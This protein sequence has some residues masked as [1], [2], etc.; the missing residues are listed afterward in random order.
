MAAGRYNGFAQALHWL[1][2]VLLAAQF[3]VAWTMPDVGRDTKPIGL[4]AWH[5]SI[6]TL[7]L[8]V[9][10]VRLG[11]RA[12]SAIPPPPEDLPASLR[13]LSRAT[14][15]LM[16]AV[17]IVLPALGWINANARG[18]TVRLAGAI[19]L[20]SLAPDGSSWGHDMGDVHM[21]VAWVLLGLVGLHVLGAVYHQ[22]VL[23]DHL[24]SRMLPGGG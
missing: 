2:L 1:V 9:I 10:L 23:R 20:P 13:L 8:L 6:G 4:I 24:L 16:Y 18:W 11:W 12:C 7:I 15:F 21:I 5:L 22:F 14:H 3:A 19:P 17:L